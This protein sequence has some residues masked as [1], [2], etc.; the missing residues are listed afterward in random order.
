MTLTM[1]C[2]V[3]C[4]LATTFSGILIN[5]G[6]EGLSSLISVK[7]QNITIECQLLFDIIQLKTKFWKNNKV[8]L[9]ILTFK[10][11]LNIS[12]LYKLIL[13][14]LNNCLFQNKKMFHMVFNLDGK[15]LSYNG[16][17]KGKRMIQYYNQ[18][19]WFQSFSRFI[20]IYK[21]QRLIHEY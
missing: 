5:S 13:S 21:F 2:A 15:D 20:D 19:Y 10:C 8:I 9:F 14:I 4:C 18:M 11:S 16:S 3:S 17:N 6:A 7:K 1:N 12:N